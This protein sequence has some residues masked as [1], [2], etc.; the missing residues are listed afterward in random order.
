MQVIVTTPDELRAMIL[1]VVNEALSKHESPRKSANVPLSMEEAAEYLKIPKSTL[2]QLTSKRLI[3]FSK[4]GR[5]S[6]FR[7]SE[8]ENWLHNR[9]KKTRQEIENEIRNPK[10]SLS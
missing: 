10:T 5:R 6:I 2:Y 1:T 9:R 3:P 4:A 8:L 7:E